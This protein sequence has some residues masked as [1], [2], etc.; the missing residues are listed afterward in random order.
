MDSENIWKSIL[1]IYLLG[2]L[3]FCIILFSTQ[4]VWPAPA[5]RLILFFYLLLTYPA[6]VIM[7]YPQYAILLVLYYIVSYGTLF[8]FRKKKTSKQTLRTESGEA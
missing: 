3:G 7:C 5:Y 6:Y 1:L 4:F 2:G 8:F